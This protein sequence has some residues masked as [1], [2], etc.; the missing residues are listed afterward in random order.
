M[1]FIEDIR[2]S[3]SGGTISP[4][5]PTF[6]TLIMTTGATSIPI[7]IINAADWQNE[8]I[9]AGF[10]VTEDAY[11]MVQQYFTPD[12]ILRI[13]PK[14]VAVIRKLDATD[15]DA[16]LD[17]LKATFNNF[18]GVL[19][20]SKTK[21]DL[22]DAGTWANVNEKFFLGSINDVTMG[23]GRSIP[24]EA[25]MI[26][27][28]LE[29]AGYQ[30]ISSTITA[31]A[32]AAVPALA[33]NT[34]DLDVTIDGGSN[35]QLAIALLA[36]DDWDGI[37]A[38]IETQLQAA[39]TSTETVVIVDG[40]IKITSVTVGAASSVL[41]AA[42]TAGSG[43]GDLLAAISA[44]AEY[45]TQIDDAVDG[46]LSWPDVAWISRK[47]A[48][49]PYKTWKWKS[50]VNQV[51]NDY[52]LAQLNTIRTN[53]TNAIT[54]QA[55][56]AFTNEGITTSG[57]YIDI[58]YGIDAVKASMETAILSLMLN[59]ESVPLTDSGITQI[60]STIRNVLEVWGQRGFIAALTPDSSDEDKAKS[61]M[62]VYMYKVIMPQRSDLSV[63]DRADRILKQTS[64][65]F[66]VAGAIHEVEITGKFEV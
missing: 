19:I 49:E 7:T 14:D 4:D 17:T 36:T 3:I 11:L 2:I 28:K 25:F 65:S 37:A 24:R 23:S 57:E 13:T 54:E 21:A 38:K 43:G 48:K 15:Y 56:V 27:D 22:Q 20:D 29:L 33:D 40:K 62:G 41:I 5:E 42:G 32:G 44:K 39:T 64:F 30:T 60:E 51:A 59:N 52:T 45:N 63:A 18:W 58:T 53:N 31:F 46:S 6:R 66:T 1:A 35:N 47:L 50:L 26:H 55:G 12:S 34:Y 61:D 8:M 10:S 9:G 16:A